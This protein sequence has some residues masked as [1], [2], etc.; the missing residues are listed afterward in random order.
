MCLNGGA[1]CI[2]VFIQKNRIFFD[3]AFDPLDNFAS[4]TSSYSSHGEELTFQPMSEFFNHIEGELIKQA[5]LISQIF[6]PEADVLYA[7]TERAI[8]DVVNE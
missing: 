6:P 3:H 8:E 2:Q 1:S 5:S 4:I 7:F